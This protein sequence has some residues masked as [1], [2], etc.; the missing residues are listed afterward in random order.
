LGKLLTK[1]AGDDDGLDVACSGF[2]GVSG[3]IRDVEAEGGVVAEDSVEVGEEGPGEGGAVDGAGSGDDCAVA[4][5][6]AGSAEGVAEDGEEADWGYDT[7]E[8]E[9]ILDLWVVR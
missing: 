5:G 4:D 2:V 1:D 8:G 9:E 3:E 7:L 6:A